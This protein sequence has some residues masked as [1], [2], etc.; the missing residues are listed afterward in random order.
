MTISAAEV[1]INPSTTIYPNSTTNVT[2]GQYRGHPARFTEKRQLNFHSRAGIDVHATP[3]TQVIL[4]RAHESPRHIPVAGIYQTGNALGSRTFLV[5]APYDYT[6][7]EGHIISILNADAILSLFKQA[8]EIVVDLHS[9]NLVHGSIMAESFVV[10]SSGNLYLSQ[11]EDMRIE[12]PNS[13]F[14][15]IGGP[16][17][18]AMAFMAPELL[19]S[20]RGDGVASLSKATD[21]YALG[22]LGFQLFSKSEPFQKYTGLSGNLAIAQV[23]LITAVVDRHERPERFAGAENIWNTLE[24]CWAPD[25]ASRPSAS[26]L[27][28]RLTSVG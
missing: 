21:I 13:P 22:C 7:L 6:Q 25:P 11:F 17:V 24:A 4:R 16:A 12:D 26:D 20:L 14:R 8:T 5:E 18:G 2:M 28:R 15:P 9:K 10:N 19:D 27:L 1:Y 23:K 3:R